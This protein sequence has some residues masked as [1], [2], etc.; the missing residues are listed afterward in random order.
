VTSDGKV[1]RATGEE[2]EDLFWALRR[3]GGNFGAVTQF[4]FRLHKIGPEVTGGLML[5]DAEMADEILAVYR[6]LT[7]AAPKDP[8][9]GEQRDHNVGVQPIGRGLGQHVVGLLRAERLR[10]TPR[11]SSGH[12]GQ[13]DH[14]PL[15][16]V[17]RHGPFHRPV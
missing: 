10:S 14:V 6:E 13:L 1:C 2:H 3:G 16:L 11:L 5:W 8:R 17:S 7:E 9:A 4:T 15:H 12:L